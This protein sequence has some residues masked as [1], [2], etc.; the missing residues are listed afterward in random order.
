[1]EVRY[2]GIA[3]RRERHYPET[4]LLTGIAL[5]II[6]SLLILTLTLIWSQIL[7]P[8]IFNSRLL[9]QLIIN[10]DTYATCSPQYQSFIQNADPPEIA[11]TSFYVYNVTNPAEVIQLGNRPNLQRLGPYAYSSQHFKYNVAF[12][13]NYTTTVSFQEYSSLQPI[14]AGSTLCQRSFLQDAISC[15]DPSNCIC[16]DPNDTVTVVNPLFA[17]TL[18]MD[19]SDSIIAYLSQDYFASIKTM[20]ENE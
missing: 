3:K 16:H 6:G 7:F 18:W 15:T 11:L 17:K 8:Y 19:G 2:K 4:R 20:L 10:K 1:M 9:F 5:M 14:D 12:D 13:V